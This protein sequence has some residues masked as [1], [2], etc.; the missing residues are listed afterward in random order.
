MCPEN[1]KILEVN[2]Y[3][4][5]DKAPFVI[6]SDLEC[7]I[8]RIDESKNK[9]ESSSTT[10]V[11]KHI[12]SGFSMSTILFKGTKSR[13]DVYGGKDSLKKFCESLREH[14]MKIIIFK[15]KKTEVINQRAAWNI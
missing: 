12:S 13:H 9:P 15:K 5:S 10:E 2:K 7:L 4:K 1:S 6:Y 11:S 14:K 3:Q 8:E